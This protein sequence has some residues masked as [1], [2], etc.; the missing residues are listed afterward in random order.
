MQLFEAEAHETAE[1]Y[2]QRDMTHGMHTSPS[3]NALW[4][5]IKTLLRPLWTCIYR[6]ICCIPIY[7]STLPEVRKSTSYWKIVFRVLLF[8]MWHDISNGFEAYWRS[9]W[10][11]YDYEPLPTY[12]RST[13]DDKM[14]EGMEGGII[15]QKEKRST[16]KKEYIFID[17]NPTLV[18]LNRHVSQLTNVSS[19]GNMEMAHV[20]WLNLA[21][22]IFRQVEFR[23]EQQKWTNK[24]RSTCL[25]SLFNTDFKSKL[26]LKHSLRLLVENYGSMVQIRL[27]IFLLVLL[28]L[29]GT[30]ISLIV[31]HHFIIQIF[32]SRFS[33]QNHAVKWLVPRTTLFFVTYCLLFS[34]LVAIILI[35]PVYRFISLLFATADHKFTDSVSILNHIAL[36]RDFASFHGEGIID[37]IRSDLLEMFDFVKNE[38]TAST[39]IE[40]VV[41]LFIDDVDKL[42]HQ[43]LNENQS[44]TYDKSLLLKFLDSLKHVLLTLDS[45]PLVSF[46][47]MDYHAVASQLQCSSHDSDNSS[48]AFVTQPLERTTPIPLWGIDYLDQNIVDTPF[49]LSEI[50][51]Q[52]IEY[53]TTATIL[54]SHN[55][56]ILKALRSVY[57]LLEHLNSL[58]S[59]AIEF[60]NVEF[61]EDLSLQDEEN[62][63]YDQRW[64]V[65]ESGDDTEYVIPKAPC[66]EES[67]KNEILNN[68]NTPNPIEPDLTRATKKVQMLKAIREDVNLEPRQQFAKFF[69]GE[70][71]TQEEYLKIINKECEEQLNSG[72]DAGLEQ[73]EESD[74]VSTTIS[75]RSDK[76]SVR[77]IKK[78]YIEKKVY[79]AKTLRKMLNEI[80]STWKHTKDFDATHNDYMKKWTRESG[81]L[82][83]LVRTGRLL[84]KNIND[85]IELYEADVPEGIELFCNALVKIMTS[86]RISLRFSAFSPRWV[87]NYAVESVSKDGNAE[88]NW[89]LIP[90]R[91]VKRII[92]D[93]DTLK[94]VVMRDRHGSIMD[95][96]GLHAKNYLEASNH[97]RIS[98]L[99]RQEVKALKSDVIKQV[100]RRDNVKAKK[101]ELFSDEEAKALREKRAR[102]AIK[103][104]L[105]IEWS[106]DSRYLV[107][108]GGCVDSMSCF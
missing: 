68:D 29:N 76:Y 34:A 19:N 13:E 22:D 59:V 49:F 88:D 101:V 9:L 36:S 97:G 79:R 47:A 50:S 18:T 103:F 99:T 54:P 52:K 84:T 35:A 56:L 43:L 41:A 5:R 62:K 1:E 6:L 58:D 14:F 46:L 51:P 81:V 64:N 100:K 15:K 89:K 85:I 80:N 95:T 61:L 37:V 104:I 93:T 21:S 63:L 91:E 86:V 107:S 108:G 23:L 57:T 42:Q 66:H 28:I 45:M 106:S 20:L 65:E 26:R 4:Y 90:F 8:G 102:Q 39:G 82:L 33:V 7:H 83:F 71:S 77:M 60:Y 16:I 25:K 48:G 98:E 92:L 94:D 78:E 24:N 55:I 3:E 2:H 40:L 44:A 70:K 75:T 73:C 31:A 17:F 27:R 32:L 38:F 67:A 72:H 69:D 53:F 74:S 105:C 87:L 10:L 30:F 11:G 12:I 96:T